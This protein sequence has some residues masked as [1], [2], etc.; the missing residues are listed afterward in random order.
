MGRLRRPITVVACAAAVVASSVVAADAKPSRTSDDATTTRQDTQQSGAQEY[1]VVFDQSAEQ[2]VAAV[3]AAGGTVLD[4][5]ED[6]GIALVTSDDAGFTG[7]VTAADGVSGAVLN[8]SVGTTEQGMAH[9]VAEVQLSAA[10]RASAGAST[11]ASRR[12]GA[13]GPEPLADRQW[14]MDMIDAPEAHRRATGRGVDVAI[15]DTGVDASHPDLAENFDA[16]RS[17]NFT[18]DIPAVDGPCEVATCIDPANV[19]HNGHGTHV[20]GI[21]GAARNGYGV[22]GVAPDANLIN[23]R[24]GNDSGYFFLYET[25][26]ALTEAGNLGVDV[27][28][29]SFYTDPWLWNCA[30]RADYVSGDVSDA[31]LAEQATVRE[32]V[33]AATF[34]ARD[35]G[36]TLVGSAGNEHT[37]LAA[38]TRADAT[39]P[40]YPPGTERERVV[41]SNCLVLPNESPAVIQTVSLGPSQTKSDFSNYGLGA[42]E[43]SAPGG[44][45]RD[46][47]GTPQHRVP[48]NMILS[49]VSL[50]GAQFRG[51]VDA[52]GN[53][54]DNTTI[55]YCDD[56][57]VCSLYAY[58]QGTSMA[59]PHTA[60]VAALVVEAHGR[61]TRHGGRALSPDRV[62]GILFDTA[63]DH[64]CPAGG[65]DDYT[66]EGRPASWNAVCTGTVDNN[67]TYGEGIVN[68]AAAVAR[69]R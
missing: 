46:F 68:A 20:A 36:V 69:R 33:L 9:Q 24:A 13:R 44:W 7:E 66:D 58:F 47:F 10:E 51:L 27:A 43:I 22:E 63:V 8:H 57:G 37:D 28:N 15:I 30:S 25:V 39:S 3:E 26:A 18:M 34:Y 45:F 31:E 65:V 19:D 12:G 62:R 53:P 59:S 60:G 49:S 55:R 48:E 14:G 38:A 56:E 64:A 50:E 17:R 41:T 29:M 42:V 21:I 6:A 5:N 4:V 52:N 54:V 23:L 67:S 1:V 16:R 40:D 35:R 61:R 32:L 11:P 2:G